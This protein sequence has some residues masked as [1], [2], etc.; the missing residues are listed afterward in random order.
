MQ[1]LKSP[2][3]IAAAKSFF[4]SGKLL[5]EIKHT[6]LTSVPKSSNASSATYFRPCNLICK[7]ITNVLSN[8]LTMIIHVTDLQRLFMNWSFRIR[9]HI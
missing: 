4:A 6:F 8:R 5:K 2:K 3:V 9:M 7:L 1:G